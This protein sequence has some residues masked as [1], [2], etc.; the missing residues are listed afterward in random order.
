MRPEHEKF[1]AGI[2]PEK[3]RKVTRLGV[4]LAAGLDVESW[5]Q[6]V[7]HLVK[8]AGRLARNRDTLTAWLGDVLAY[9]GGKYHGQIA[10]Y[11]R[12]AGMSPGTLRDAKLVCSRIPVARRNEAL[13]WSHHCEVGKAF[14]SLDEIERWLSFAAKEE[15]ATMAL[16]KR[17]RAHIAQTKPASPPIDLGAFRLLRELRAIDRLLAA[18]RLVWNTW[19]PEARERALSELATLSEFVTTLNG[20]GL[21]LNAAS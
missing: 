19:T 6:L 5:S 14:S 8:T 2:A 10:E 13:S 12:A 15:L 11:A 21:T 17:I 9:G 16:R 7:A 20:M 18:D 4:E 1:I 3:V